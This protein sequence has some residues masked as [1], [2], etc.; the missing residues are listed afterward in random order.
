MRL[1]FSVTLFCAC[2]VASSPADEVKLEALSPGTQIDLTGMWSYKPGYAIAKEESPQNPDA[3][4]DGYVSIPVPQILNQIHWWLDDSED[5]KKNEAA[6]L[7]KLGFDT[8]KAEDG[9][10]R[11]TIELSP[12]S[13]D[14]NTHIF[15][16]FDGVAMRSDVYINGHKLGHHDGMFSRF[17]F[18]L[19]DHL[20]PGKNVLVVFVSM[21]R[22]PP[23]KA[24]LGEAVT[25]NLTAS[26]IL[27]MSK[28]MFGPLSPGYPNRAYDLHGI[29][30][31]VRLVVRGAASIQ[32]VFFQPS[33]TGAKIDIEV[34]GAVES[35]WKLNASL[36][37][38]NGDIVKQVEQSIGGGK[39]SLVLADM[40]P[41]LWTPADPNLYRL[42]VTLE[43]KDG[44]IVDA[45]VHQV[46]FRTFEAKNGQLLLN[47]RPYYLRGANQL[48]Y[49]KNPTDPRLARRLIQQLH[50]N[51][52]RMTRTHATPWNEAWLDAADE[53][54]LGVSVEGIRP[55]ALCGKIGPTPP[56]MMAHWLMEHEDVVKRGRNHPSVLIWTI[57]NEM[58]LR[59]DDNVEKWKQLT[60]V[61]KQTR[62][63]DPSR[64]IVCSS[65]YIRDEKQYN[66]ILAPNDI[67]DGDIDDAHN[68]NA[69]YAPSPFVTES[70]YTAELK[71]RGNIKRVFMGQE[72]STGYPDLDTGL[73]VLRYT[74]DLMTP[75]A[76][77]G[78]YAYPGNDPRW[79]LEYNR[80][81]T[82]RWAEQLRAQRGKNTFG[83][84]LFSAECWFNHSYDPKRATAYPVVEAVKQAYEPVGLMLETGQRRFYSG[85]AV[86]TAYYIT[87]D[88][89]QFRDHKRLALK[90]EFVDPSSGQSST[91][92]EVTGINVAYFDRVKVST[93]FQLPHADS[94]RK[95]QLVAQLMAAG[96]PISRTVDSIDVFPFIEK[97]QIKAAG[98]LEEG[99]S[100]AQKGETA[101][102]FSPDM[103][104]M[105]K[106]F[107]DDVYDDA[108]VA[109]ADYEKRVADARAKGQ[110]PPRKPQAGFAFDMK[111]DI[112]EFGDWTPARGTK[113]VDGLEPMDLRWW[114]RKNDWK[115]YVSTGSFRLKETGKARE[116]VRYI[117]AHS[118]I[119]SEKVPWQLRTVLFEI[120]VGKGR[121]WICN[122]NFDDSLGVDPVADLLARNLAA[123]AADPS[124]TSTL[125]MTPSHEQML[126]GKLPN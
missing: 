98:N 91:A 102:V 82:K 14:K 22:I 17:E 126:A 65:T 15:V 35:G 12:S 103:K 83:F 4:T 13:L 95:L 62:Q 39:A 72:Q 23:A 97:P 77:V 40:N 78:V 32:D 31:P 36:A 50:D 111:K 26:K 106:R 6:R 60:Q 29:W 56:D 73:P 92:L 53:I 119:P 47:G 11:K 18:D 55:W 87:N 67:D 5:F 9:W 96:R 90:L 69:W 114:A 123:A 112:G 108:K 76:W 52:I 88:D 118:Y 107:P 100:L 70:K 57:G 63:L 49:G 71:K 120:P 3:T 41:R 124:S 113:L 27:S 86:E 101:I 104:E 59:D 110:D 75:Q 42:T 46:G 80:I 2:L 74:R 81:V 19:T 125:K 30:Q 25:V 7:A 44:N 121:L 24:T 58:M 34:A 94:R 43:K 93:R 85:Q 89:E 68:Y 16:Q 20:K 45:W 109:E 61:V 51:N 48:P 21:E 28:G 1:F 54:G 38:P 116:L 33:L 8:E 37:N 105:L 117:P 122:L 66:K 79:F 115:V 10:Y 84:S 64:P 99:I